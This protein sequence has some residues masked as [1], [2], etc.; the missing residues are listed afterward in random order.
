MLNAENQ[1]DHLKVHGLKKSCFIATI[2]A[3]VIVF[4]FKLKMFSFYQ[5]FITNIHNKSQQVL[6]LISL[7]LKG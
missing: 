4:Y 3:L 1:I 2:F 6:N 7:Y 5:H